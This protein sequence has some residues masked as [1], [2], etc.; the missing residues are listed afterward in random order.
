MPRRPNAKLGILK[1]RHQVTELYLRG[2]T[3]MAI[4]EQMGVAQGTVCADL[5]AIRELWE[6]S[7]VRNFDLA[8]EEELKKLAM[9]ESE[10]WAAWERSQKPTQEA[11]VKDNDQAGAVKKMKSRHGDLRCMDVLLRCNSARRDLLGLDLAT[12]TIE[13][14]NHAHLHEGDTL[15]ERRQRLLAIVDQFRQRT[16][17]VDVGEP[18]GGDQPN[19]VRTD[20]QP[21]EVDGGPTL[22]LSGPGDP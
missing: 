13:L 5:K 4:A 3:Q 6:E 21:G 11:H 18:A 9:I 10:T 14:H 17:I 8:R 12:P 7:L 15:D 16:G 20:R 19:D 22:G 2:H 1:R